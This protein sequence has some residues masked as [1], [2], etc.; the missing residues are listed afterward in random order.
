MQLIPLNKPGYFRSK[1]YDNINWIFWRPVV[2]G[3][4]TYTEA[5]S[6]G[7]S[8]LMEANAAL[9]RRIKEENKK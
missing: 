6:L 5:S 1:V 4:L 7:V 2:H 8:E 3:V 9:D